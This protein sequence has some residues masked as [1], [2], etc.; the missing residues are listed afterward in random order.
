MSPLE[1]KSCRVVMECG[2]APH[3][4]RIGGMTLGA[5]DRERA[6]GG[7]LSEC[8]SSDE[9]HQYEEPLHEVNL[10]RG[11]IRISKLQV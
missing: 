9:E 5:C 7:L 1:R 6:V 10:S 11:M 8:S 2:V 3:L 4:P